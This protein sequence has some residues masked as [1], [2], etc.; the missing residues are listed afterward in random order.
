LNERKNQLNRK[1]ILQVAIKFADTDGIDKLNMR[2]LA[3][4]LDSPVMTLY[5]HVENKKE[6]INGMVDSIASEMEVS[7]RDKHWREAISEI[8]LTA[9]ETFYRHPWALG[10][11]S[12]VGGPKKLQHEE[13][14]LRVLREAGFSVAL[15]CR[16]YHAITMHII[17]FTTQAIG[18]PRNA[19]AMKSAAAGFL[20]HADSN[21]IPYF[22]E[23]VQH[24]FDHPESDGV[25]EFTLNMILDGLEK[26]MEKP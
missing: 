17:G 20:A 12:S 4:Q 8:A 23:H 15:S 1:R 13:S 22:V 9:Y 19:A 2:S 11:W 21:E 5:S 18:F 10:L 7:E 24:H 3:K 6:L 16:G 25:F 26:H 14:V